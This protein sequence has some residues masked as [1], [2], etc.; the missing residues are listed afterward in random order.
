MAPP[1][2]LLSPLICRLKRIVEWRRGL[3]GGGVNKNSGLG[4]ASRQVI[5]KSI[6][7]N[8]RPIAERCSVA[9]AIHCSALCRFLCGWRQAAPQRQRGGQK[10]TQSGQPSCR[11]TRLT[12]WPLFVPVLS[13]P[14][15][16]SSVPSDSTA[17]G[18]PLVLALRGA[19][20][21]LPCLK[22]VTPRATSLQLLA[23]ILG[24]KFVCRAHLH[25]A[26]PCSSAR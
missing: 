21:W 12:A 4:M 13:G 10:D 2:P 5:P 9:I 24:S 11:S 25:P 19:H 15:A 6:Q 8:S 26:V 14:V 16:I 18:H 1:A 23:K 17:C 7:G 20:S 3:A 22:I